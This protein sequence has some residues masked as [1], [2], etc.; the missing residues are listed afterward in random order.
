MM[1]ESLTSKKL[2]DVATTRAT[3][4]AIRFLHGQLSGS[5]GEL[6]GMGSLR[7]VPAEETRK[8]VPGRSSGEGERASAEVLTGLE[9]AEAH[10]MPLS[11][12][13]EGSIVSLTLV[14]LLGI[15]G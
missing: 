15:W 5:R 12:F 1:V 10:S 8:T 7:T 4:A 3:S 14:C 6:D 11:A 13:G 2:T 9:G